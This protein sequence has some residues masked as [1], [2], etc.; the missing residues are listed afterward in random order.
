MKKKLDNLMKNSYT[1]NTK[2]YIK[3]LKANNLYNLT[4]DKTFFNLKFKKKE[5]FNIIS[6]INFSFS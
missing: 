5:F 2:R 4:Q 6:F 3:Y 1:P